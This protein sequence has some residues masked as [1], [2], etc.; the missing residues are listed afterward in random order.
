MDA[1][2]AI[3]FKT[4]AGIKD[5][6]DELSTKPPYLREALNVDID[7]AGKILSRRDGFGAA[8]FS[9]DYHSLWSNRKNTI[10]LA[11]SNTG[12]LV[13]VRPGASLSV[14]RSGLGAY[15][16]VDFEEINGEIYYSS[17]VKLGCLA[18]PNFPPTNI[19]TEGRTP[20]PPGRFIQYY[21]GKLY[22]VS[23]GS[24]RYSEG[25]DLGR[26][27][28]YKNF[29]AVPG[30][31]T[32]FKAVEDGIY[33]SYGNETVFIRGNSPEEFMLSQVA[34][35]AVI[36]GTAFKFDASL[37]S[38]NIPLQGDAVFWYSDQG[39]CIGFAGGKMLNLSLTKHNALKG[40]SGTA[41]ARKNNKG[42]Y[43]ALTILNN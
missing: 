14:L 39:A 41:I 20:M 19:D 5:A 16:P 13:Q 23:G 40:L 2:P 42:F 4:F 7:D 33:C 28:R 17:A 38:S 30:E 43:Q 3:K 37:V 10:M 15:M 18:D 11:V 34:D 24:I 22:S 1:V 9:G 29:L 25:Y 12:D 26:T 27:I 32:M 31:V 36:P 35:Y 6:V 21:R 8:L